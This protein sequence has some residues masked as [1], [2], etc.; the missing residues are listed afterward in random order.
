MEELRSV[1]EELI[2]LQTVQV[3]EKVDEIDLP[4]DGTSL[5]LLQKIYRSS[6]IPLSTRMRA[7]IA[8]I[9]FEHPKL[10]VTASI[11][12]GDFAD[13]LD[14]AVERSRRVLMIEAKPITEANV[15]SNAANVSANAPSNTTRP[16]TTNGH[17]PSVPDRRYRRW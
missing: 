12:A 15:S 13:Q 14:R 5:T 3:Q 16:V 17:K 8:A 6:A 7:A 9:Q 4:Q 1:M 10:A 2:D 11:Q